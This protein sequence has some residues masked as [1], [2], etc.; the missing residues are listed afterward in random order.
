MCAVSGGR[1]SMALLHLLS[2]L[3]EDVGFQ[4]A[5][6]HFNH[7]LRDTAGRDEDFVREWCR[8]HGIPFACG[9]GDVRGFAK[10]EGLSIEDAARVLRYEFLENAAADLGADRIA[11]AHHREDNA[12]TLLLHLIRGAGLQGLS[13]IPPVRGKI[14]RPLLNA[15]RDEINAYIERYALP[16]VEDESNQDTAYTRNRLRLEVLPLLEEMAPGCGGRISRTAGLLREENQHIQSEADE[17]LPAVKDSTI[18]LPVPL[19]EEKDIVLKRRLVRG[20]ALRL[21]GSLNLRQTDAVLNL[22]SNGFLDLPGGLCAVRTRQDLTLKLQS[23]PPSPLDLHEGVQIW[24]NWHVS[25]ERR[26]APAA[27]TE[28]CMVLRDRGEVLTIAPW[29]GSG[30]LKVENGCRTIKRLFADKGIPIGER[31]SHPALLAD[32]KIVAVAGVAVDWDYRPAGGTVLQIVL[33]KI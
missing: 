27:E 3:A 21:G 23:P 8:K 17:L 7:Q 25:V 6:G 20:M 12:E 14:V 30:R 18:S 31:D 33:Q 15:S 11:A 4:V 29:D 9:R 10:R 19:L 32:G 22:K 28:C 24:G 2:S 16:F 26:D 13:G 5:A 1:D